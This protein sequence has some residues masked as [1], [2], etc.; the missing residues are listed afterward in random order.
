MSGIAFRSPLNTNHNGFLGG[1]SIVKATT[2]LSAYFEVQALVLKA[3]KAYNKNNPEVLLPEPEVSTDDNTGLSSLSL[4]MPY[5]RVGTDKKSV[6]YIDAYTTYA[7]PTTGEL[8]GISNLLDAF[9][10][11]ADS[12]DQTLQQMTP[13]AFLADPKGLVSV[14]D[15]GTSRTVTSALPY[16][17]HIDDVTGVQTNIPVNGLIFYDLEVGNVP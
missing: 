3:Y 4:N 5:R 9:W 17:V 14:A 2:L 16:N 6:G 15:N 13:N 8:T 1:D 12:L 7:T 11:I 10:Y